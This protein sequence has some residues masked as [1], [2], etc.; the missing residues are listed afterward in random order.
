V[1]SVHEPDDLLS[2]AR[3]IARE[4]ADHAAPVSV[5][6]TRRMLWRMLGEPHPMHAHR[7]DSRGVQAR[8]QAA[9]AAEGVR[10]FFEKRPAVFPDRVSDGLPDLFPGWQPPPFE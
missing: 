3:A 9:D 5:A 10:S 6:L 4:I 8:G 7:V 1:R 2:A